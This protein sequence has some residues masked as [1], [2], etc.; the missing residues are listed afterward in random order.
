MSASDAIARTERDL[1]PTCSS[2]MGT[3]P[4]RFLGVPAYHACSTSPGRCSAKRTVHRRRRADVAIGSGH[5]PGSSSWSKPSAIRSDQLLTPAN[6][7]D[8][9]VSTGRSSRGYGGKSSTKARG[10]TIRMSRNGSRH[11][12]SSSPLTITD[13]FPERAS[14][15]NLSSSG[16]GLSVTVSRTDRWLHGTGVLRIAPFPPPQDRTQISPG[17]LHRRTLRSWPPRQGSGSDPV[18]CRRPSV[19][20]RCGSKAH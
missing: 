6:L 8:G 9:S 18:P 11:R 2:R 7:G 12:R 16:S 3:T 14:S 1:R 13:A 20:W 4:P 5:L 19:R 10:G 15:R 17:S